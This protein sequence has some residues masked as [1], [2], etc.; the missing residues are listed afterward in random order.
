LQLFEF[1][2]Q[3][4]LPETL[5]RH[6]TGLLH[7]LLSTALWADKRSARELT[8]V[9]GDLIRRSGSGRVVDLCAG[10][11]G[12]WS[13]LQPLLEAETGDKLTVQLTDLFPNL[14]AFARAE[15]ERPGR[16]FGHAEPVDA[17]S[18]PTELVGVRTWF[19]AL[20][21]FPDDLAEAM[22]EDAVRKDQPVFVCEGT[23][24]SLFS[25]FWMLFILPPLVWV[26]TPFIRPFDWRWV[27]LTYL[28]PVT[29]SMVVFDGLV[30]VMRIRTT[31]ELLALATR[32]DPEG[33]FTWR[34]DS[35]MPGE[36]G[37]VYL[38]GG[39]ADQGEDGKDVADAF[40]DP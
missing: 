9:L 16:V 10:A 17:T 7:W 2:D 24:R 11:G 19:D 25:L 36:L 34:A 39:P 1:N 8:A 13:V 32:A 21:H 4:W 3:R 14:P 33:R 20:H 12:P 18:V 26:A 5:R 37:W 23:S 22:L 27:P 38:V 31:E 28:L 35:W 29:V 6:L 15:A 40:A 30:S